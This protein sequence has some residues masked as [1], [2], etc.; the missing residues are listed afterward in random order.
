MNEEAERK[1]FKFWFDEELVSEMAARLTRLEPEF[2]RAK[3]RKLATAGLEE[4]EMMERVGLIAA[5]LHATLPGPTAR[6]LD[7]LVRSLPPAA[8]VDE[9][10]VEGG[11]RFWPYGEYIARYGADDV[12]ASFAA[13]IELTQRF[14]SE[15]AV[16]PFLAAD[17]RGSLKRLGRLTKHRSQHVRRWVSEGTRTRLPWAKKIPELTRALDERLALLDALRHDEARYVQ[18]SVANHLADILKDDPARGKET[19]VRWAQEGHPGLD[20][21]VRHAARTLLKAGDPEALA[22]FGYRAVPLEV[23]SFSVSPKRVAIGEEVK[24]SARITSR[25]ARPILVRIDYALSSPTKTGKL[26]RKVFRWTE[27]ELLPGADVTLEKRHAFVHRTIR[28]IHPGEHG[29]ELLVNGQAQ[30]RVT[31][32]VR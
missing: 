8:Q 6:A 15:F 18:R 13:M 29:F 21:I 17:L 1:A 7:M 14:S 22:L 24:L 2:P 27:L 3:F 10:M 5:A 9:G 25:G 31:A 20:W 16:R 4:L 12:E 30:G 19:L 11:Y 23:A 28:T 26:A 32:R